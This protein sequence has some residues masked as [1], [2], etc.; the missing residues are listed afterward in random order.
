M[1]AVH[2]PYSRTKFAGDLLFT[3]GHVGRRTDG[4]LDEG[5]AEQTRQTLENLEASLIDVGLNRNDIV[6][7]TVYLSEMSLWDEMNVPYRAFFNSQLPARSAVCVGLPA[8]ILIEIDAV[9]V[10]DASESRTAP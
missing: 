7:V 9:A 10:R 3:S 6:R 1:S 4:T 2:P 8:G 5:I